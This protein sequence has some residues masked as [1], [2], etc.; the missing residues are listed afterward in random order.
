[1]KKLN[2]I[3]ISKGGKLEVSSKIRLSDN[4]IS[5]AYTP[6]VAKVSMAVHKDPEKAYELTWKKRSVAII[7]DGSAV[8]GLGNI[9]P[10]AALPVM[11]AKALLF[12]QLGGIDAVPIVLDTQDPDK[13]VEITKALAPG[14]GGINM[15]DIAAPNCFIIKEQLKKE[16]DIP[17]FH[18]DQYGTAI[19]VLAGLINASKAIGKD[20]TKCRRIVISGAGAAG[21]ATAKTLAKFG[22]A[23]SIIV[24]DSTGAIYR[25]RKRNMNFAKIRISHKTNPNKFKG[26]MKEAL[27][28]AE[29]FIGLSSANLLSY[30]DIQKMGP[31]PIVFALANPGPEILPDEAR[32]G[33]AAIVATGRSDFPNQINNA[34][35]FPGLFKGVMKTR[36]CLITDKHKRDAALALAATIKKPMV[37]KL[38]PKVTDRRA[39]NA[40][41]KV[42]K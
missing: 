31:D 12:K 21:M 36:T 22:C 38:L 10:K 37:N 8:L 26:A 20:V 40:I 35:V 16:L 15:E 28:G 11:E 24:Y 3:Q 4:N 41:A 2:P 32:K 27:N 29:V 18:D 19:V 34:L 14:F 6:G 7:S 42:F 23:N 17:V 25:G 33:G 30:V 9:G 1:M 39:V 5:E 13:I